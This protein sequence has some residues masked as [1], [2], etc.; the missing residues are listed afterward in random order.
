MGKIKFKVLKCISTLALA[1]CMFLSFWV[2]NVSAAY[3]KY[4]TYSYSTGMLWWKKTYNCTVYKDSAN[5]FTLWYGSSNVSTGFEYKNNTSIVLSQ[6]NSFSLSSQT[7]ASLNS[8]VNVEACGIKAG[9]GGSLSSTS[10]QTWAVSSTS[11]RTIEKS[12]PKGYY[13]Y[14]VCMNTKK[15][16][17]TGTSEGTVYVYVPVSEAYRSIVYNKNNAS[18]SGVVR[19]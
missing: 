17:I 19:Y 12:A 13:S 16:K 8:N 4:S 18:Y 11:T 10:A 7:T 15:L 6:T 14:N 1:L 2:E 9:I 3:S 5:Y